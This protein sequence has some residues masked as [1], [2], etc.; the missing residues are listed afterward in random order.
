[1]FCVIS[2]DNERHRGQFRQYRSNG[3]GDIGILRFSNMA[4]AIMDFRKFKFLPADT[5]ER[6]N[7]RI[8]AC[9]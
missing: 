2:I 5:F 1:M 6:P 9:R 3:F 8:P 7:L 4:A